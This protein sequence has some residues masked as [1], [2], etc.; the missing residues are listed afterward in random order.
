[1]DRTSV[2]TCESTV[3][4]ITGGITFES[5]VTSRTGDKTCESRVMDITTSITWELTVMDRTSAITSGHNWR[6]NLKINSYGDN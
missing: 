3:M 4:D 5:I 1:M 6:H 2:K